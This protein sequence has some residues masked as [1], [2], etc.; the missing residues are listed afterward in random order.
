[1]QD[2][3][4]IWDEGTPLPLFCVSI[5]SKR[6]SERVGVGLDSFVTGGEGAEEF[7]RAPG[8]RGAKSGLRAEDHGKV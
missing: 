4:P 1:M 3:F 2:G 8:R 5:H 6:V 7:L